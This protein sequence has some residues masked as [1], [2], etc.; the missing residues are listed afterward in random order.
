MNEKLPPQLVEFIAPLW[1]W[2]LGALGAVVG[3]LEDFK[4]DDP[5]RVKILKA[6]TRLSSSSLAALLTYSALKALQVPES[7][8]VVLIGISGHMGV[9][10]LK[11][12]GEFYKSRM[13]GK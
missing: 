12:L 2:A 8:H 1:V 9:E 5:M 6:F 7:W 3:Y 11:Q 10:A 13:G 4:I